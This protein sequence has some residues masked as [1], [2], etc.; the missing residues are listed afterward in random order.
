MGEGRVPDYQVLS[1]WTDPSP[2]KVAAVGL[3]TGSVSAEWSVSVEDCKWIFY[4]V[5][6]EKI[7]LNV[8]IYNNYCNTSNTASTIYFE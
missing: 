6:H 7:E 4:K 2:T 8:S 1:S 3:S 5:K